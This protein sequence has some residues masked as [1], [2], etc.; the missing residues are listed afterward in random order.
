MMIRFSKIESEIS[1]EIER[2]WTI[3]LD[4]RQVITLQAFRQT[5]KPTLTHR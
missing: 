3:A 1:F 4:L 2:N 5:K